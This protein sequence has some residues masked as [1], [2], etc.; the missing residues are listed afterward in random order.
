MCYLSWLLT[1]VAR[2]R[3]FTEK[4][5]KIKDL[6]TWPAEQRMIRHHLHRRH[7]QVDREKKTLTVTE[8]PFKGSHPLP[9]ARESRPKFMQC[10]RASEVQPFRP[11]SF[12]Y[13]VAQSAT[14]DV[15]SEGKRRELG[16]KLFE[17]VPPPSAPELLKQERQK[18]K[19]EEERKRKEKERRKKSADQVGQGPIQQGEPSEVR[20]V[21]SCLRSPTSARSGSNTKKRVRFTL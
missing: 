16:R 20:S 18:K 17:C 5:K 1:S 10:L 2:Y 11:G 13:L 6:T 19:E 9:G 12:G 8:G 7:V 4:S 21:P 14:E 3:G 15:R